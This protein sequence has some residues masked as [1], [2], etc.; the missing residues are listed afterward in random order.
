MLT[1]QPESNLPP[2]SRLPL[3]RYAAFAIGL[4]A[5]LVIAGLFG[6]RELVDYS[7][8]FYADKPIWEQPAGLFDSFGEPLE[9]QQSA[10]TLTVYFTAGDGRLHPQEFHSAVELNDYQKAR[11]VLAQLMKGP[12][13][14]FLLSTLPPGAQLRSVFLLNDVI[15]VNLNERSRANLSGGMTDEWLAVTAIANSLLVNLKKFRA[16][17]FLIEGNAVETFSGAIDISA[18]LKQNFMLIGERETS[19]SSKF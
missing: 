15:V 7:G 9:L 13:E 12:R 10:E 11:F 4:S 6:L 2:R 19:A 3:I 14:G 8:G 16:V 18:P 1:E 5:L 17:Q